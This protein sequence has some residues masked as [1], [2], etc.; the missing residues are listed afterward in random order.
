[1]ASIAPSVATS[2]F[3]QIVEKIIA[4]AFGNARWL[5]L[6][7]SLPA[8]EV[9]PASLLLT[10]VAPLSAIPV[11]RLSGVLA[12]YGSLLISLSDGYRRVCRGRW[13]GS[14][15]NLKRGKQS[16]QILLQNG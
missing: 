10:Q 3:Y 9:G 12:V 16:L 15:I 13:L 7:A 6:V 8:V 5:R 11:T 14:R 1:M 2:S 4:N